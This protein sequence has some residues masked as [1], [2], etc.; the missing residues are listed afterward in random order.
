MHGFDQSHI[1]DEP[2]LYYS[3]VGII[4]LLDLAWRM[5]GFESVV[6]PRTPDMST[7]CSVLDFHPSCNLNSLH[8]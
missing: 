8:V 7:S 1:V 4:S 5:L 3:E 2:A 6:H